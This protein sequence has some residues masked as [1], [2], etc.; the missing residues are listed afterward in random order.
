MPLGLLHDRTA[1]SDNMFRKR[2]NDS[3][4]DIRSEHHQRTVNSIASTCSI[5]RLVRPYSL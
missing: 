3:I 4:V 2:T 1:L 5:S